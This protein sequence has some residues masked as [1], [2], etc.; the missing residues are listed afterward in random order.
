MFSSPFRRKASTGTGGV[1]TPEASSPAAAR[2]ATPVLQQH[3]L[4]LP[5]L[6]EAASKPEEDAVE[7][8]LEACGEGDKLP[9]LCGQCYEM[10][11]HESFAA[12]AAEAAGA[13]EDTCMPG[14]G[15]LSRF[16]STPA[17]L[18]L[19][20][21]LP[22]IPVELACYYLISL[23]GLLGKSPANVE[24]AV[25]AAPFPAAPSAH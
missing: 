11:F 21:M 2:L 14:S 17:L 25:R 15:S 4:P 3:P 20:E 10:L 13:T 7:K 8:A 18:L 5:K 1:A 12:W 6:L 19:V 9:Q 16:R 22:L 23:Q 24:F